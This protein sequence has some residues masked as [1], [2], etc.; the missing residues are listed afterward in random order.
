M[1][2]ERESR[3]KLIP[4]ELADMMIKAYDKERRLPASRELTKTLGQKVEDTQSVWIS[5]EALVELLELN[6]ADG[7]RLYFGLADDYPG[8][9]LRNAEYRK[10]HTVIM[11][12]TQSKDPKNPTMENS[13]DC[14]SI[15]KKPRLGKDPNDTTGPVVMNITNSQAGMPADDIPLCP[16]P[17]TSSCCLLPLEE[18]S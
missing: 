18:I 1:K 12:A 3:L 16:P 15:P 8:Y 14:L 7:I 9:K 11:V 2:E 5:K 4:V 13:V 17:Y 6:K 10:K